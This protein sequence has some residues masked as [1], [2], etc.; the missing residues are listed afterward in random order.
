MDPIG[1]CSTA[2]RIDTNK[3]AP[4]NDLNHSTAWPVQENE[5]EVPIGAWNWILTQARRNRASS[6]WCARD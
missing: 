6:A 5:K 3:T 1:E 4:A 2:S